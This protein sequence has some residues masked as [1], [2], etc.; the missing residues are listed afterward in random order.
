MTQQAQ[1]HRVRS[2]ETQLQSHEAL[3]HTAQSDRERQ[4]IQDRIDE[5]RRDL[6]RAK[7]GKLV[8]SQ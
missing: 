4:H 2:I 1:A 8:A 6:E 3:L 5:F 7:A